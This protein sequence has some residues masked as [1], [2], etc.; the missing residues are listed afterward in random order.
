[1]A[2]GA[3]TLTLEEFQILQELAQL[4]PDILKSKLKVQERFTQREYSEIPISPVKRQLVW[5]KLGQYGVWLAC[6]L[7][8]QEIDNLEALKTELLK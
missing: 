1:L 8:S 6:S 2:L 7:I 3:Q 5:Q 4:P